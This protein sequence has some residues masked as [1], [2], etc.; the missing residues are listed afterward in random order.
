MV[1]ELKKKNVKILGLVHY[2]PEI[3]KSGLIGNPIGRC[4]AQEDVKTIID[5][6]EETMRSV[7]DV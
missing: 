6:L 3:V 2:D 4:N 7:S 5:R 1:E